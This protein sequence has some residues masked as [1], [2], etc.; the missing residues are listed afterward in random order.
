MLILLAGCAA[1][2]PAKKPADSFTEHGAL[3]MQTAPDP[4][5]KHAVALMLCGKR[6]LS[7]GTP[8]FA[9]CVMELHGRDRALSRAR[10]P[11][12]A[13]QSAPR[14]TLCLT[15]GEFTLTRCYEI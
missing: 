10:R 2:P 4:D 3:V 12:S 5:S 11:A 14:G 15:P 13:A 7:E 1:S 6:G 8:P 9:R